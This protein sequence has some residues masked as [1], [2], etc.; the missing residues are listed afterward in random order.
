MV[1]K[2]IGHS[3]ENTRGKSET[4]GNIKKIPLINRN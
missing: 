1:N 4:K 2:T 3:G